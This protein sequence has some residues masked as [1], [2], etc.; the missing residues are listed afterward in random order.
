MTSQTQNQ[1][2]GQT[3]AGDVVLEGWYQR[4]RLRRLF[5][6]GDFRD[7]LTPVATENLTCLKTTRDSLD[8]TGETVQTNAFITG[9]DA[10]RCETDPN[11]VPPEFKNQTVKIL[12]AGVRAD[13]EFCSQ[14]GWNPCSPDMD[15][16]RCR[17]V[18]AE[19]V[20]IYTVTTYTD[21]RY[22]GR[23]RSGTKTIERRLTEHGSRPR[24]VEDYRLEVIG[25][26]CGDCRGT[27]QTG[28]TVC[29]TCSG[30]GNA[31]IPCKRCQ[32]GRTET[33]NQCDGTGRLT[34]EVCHG[35]GYAMQGDVITRTYRHTAERTYQLDDLVAGEFKNGLSE[36]SFTSL[37]GDLVSQVTLAPSNPD[38]VS[39]QESVH[40]YDV[41]SR[42]YEYKDAE[43]CLN[44]I[45]SG[46]G[47]E[48][49]VASGLPVSWL[50]AGIAAALVGVP[51]LAVAAVLLAL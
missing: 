21:V 25:K 41:D 13:C 35:A 16:L 26:R 8:I 9:D 48:E 32:G 15:C 42:R 46:S 19:Q 5:L 31:S 24:N 2:A 33:C 1:N 12:P 51:V 27:G 28:V 50:K 43:V 18:G 22:G 38:T 6:P 4:A 14:G 7:R 29:R 37:Q 45:S 10:S 23:V 49:Y 34:C 44:R 47:D 39:M 36:N 30:H 40:S 11:Y 17:G 3:R 20:V